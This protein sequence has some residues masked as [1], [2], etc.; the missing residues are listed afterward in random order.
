MKS[1]V[2]QLWPD[3]EFVRFEDIR[4]GDSIVRGGATMYGEELANNVVVGR[5]A[6]LH[7]NSYDGR[8]SWLPDDGGFSSEL[9]FT[10]EEENHSDFHPWFYRI[11]V[12]GEAAEPGS[13]TTSKWTAGVVD[14]VKGSLV[15]VSREDLTPGMV[16]LTADVTPERVTGDGIFENQIY[17]GRLGVPNRDDEGKG[18]YWYTQDANLNFRIILPEEYDNGGSIFRVG[19]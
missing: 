5:A 6:Y 3:G 1:L 16:V 9:A 14:S 2:Q 7:I 4:L 17:I 11:S 10:G 19:I 18:D 15:E 12:A 8:S 13:P